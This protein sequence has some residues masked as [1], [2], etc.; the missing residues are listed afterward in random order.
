M[1]KRFVTPLYSWH[2]PSLRSCITNPWQCMRKCNHHDLLPSYHYSF[3]LYSFISFYFV[4]PFACNTWMVNEQTSEWMN[5]CVNEWTNEWASDCLRVAC[6]LRLGHD[7]VPPHKG[8]ERTHNSCNIQS[9]FISNYILAYPLS[10]RHCNCNYILQLSA[11]SRGSKQHHYL[12]GKKSFSLS[13]LCLVRHLL[14]K[15]NLLSLSA[16][17]LLS[18]PLFISLFPPLLGCLSSY[19]L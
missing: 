7:S 1:N 13:L 5:A 16:V 12:Q 11:T 2:G 19:W 17:Q 18:N 8:P 14:S 6:G 10:S 9:P 15:K 4:R 3:E